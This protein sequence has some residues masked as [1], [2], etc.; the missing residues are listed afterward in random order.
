MGAAPWNP[1]EVRVWPRS[2]PQARLSGLPQ[3]CP[4]WKNHQCEEGVKYSRDLWKGADV[5][6]KVTYWKH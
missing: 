5:S 4:N 6:E 1:A 2:A 3:C